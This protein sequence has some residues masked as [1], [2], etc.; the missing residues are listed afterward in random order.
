MIQ[1]ISKP[2]SPTCFLHIFWNLWASTTA[3]KQRF[4]II[5]LFLNNDI[6]SFQALLKVAGTEKN[7]WNNKWWL[8]ATN[9]RACHKSVAIQRESMCRSQSTY[10]DLITLFNI[11]GLANYWYWKGKPA[12]CCTLTISIYCLASR[13]LLI[14][15]LYT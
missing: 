6:E 3:K 15:V 12:C 8:Q 7:N 10:F 1:Q 2:S 13:R 14:P 5:Y 4:T 9:S 11:Q